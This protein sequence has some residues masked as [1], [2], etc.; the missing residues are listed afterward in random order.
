MSKKEKTIKLL[1]KKLRK[2]EA[3]IKKLKAGKTGKKTGKKT[4]KAKT[5]KTKTDKTKTDKT[6]KT[7]KESATGAPAKKDARTAQKTAKRAAEKA[8]Q[9]GDRKP[10]TVTALPS[11]AIKPAAERVKT[12]ANE[13]IAPGLRADAE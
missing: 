11:V 6:R 2:A 8:G 12:V 9:P 4:D 10:A 13:P 7:A 1:K 3:E 5:G